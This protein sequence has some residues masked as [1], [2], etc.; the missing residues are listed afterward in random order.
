[1]KMEFI[2]PEQK[3]VIG[4]DDMEL[5][6]LVVAE[7]YPAIVDSYLRTKFCDYCLREYI[8]WD[9]ISTQRDHKE[10]V[11]VCYDCFVPAYSVCQGV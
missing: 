10:R 7:E 6:Y 4:R 1:M 11:T 3:I 8:V 2:I 5:V 9:L